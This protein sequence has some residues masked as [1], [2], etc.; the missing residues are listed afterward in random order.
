[1]E[2]LKKKFQRRRYQFKEKDLQG[3]IFRN[4]TGTKGHAKE[5]MGVKQV[6]GKLV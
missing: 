6:A 4:T 5:A 3:N 1:M 2:N